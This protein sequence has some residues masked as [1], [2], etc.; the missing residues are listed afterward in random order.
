MRPNPAASSASNP[1]LHTPVYRIAR[2]VEVQNN[3][4][5]SYTLEPHHNLHPTRKGIMLQMGN[6][7]RMVSL[8]AISNKLPSEQE[9]LEWREEVEKAGGP[10]GLSLEEV[11]EKSEIFRLLDMKYP[12]MNKYGNMATTTSPAE[13]MPKIQASQQSAELE[14]YPF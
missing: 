1:G 6:T 2:I 8:Q 11:Q 12:A 7:V 3:C 10:T 5:P 4:Y 9:Y 13:S 14:S